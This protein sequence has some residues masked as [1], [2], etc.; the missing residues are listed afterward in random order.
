MK[1]EFYRPMQS[2]SRIQAILPIK[3]NH[4]Q[5]IRF[6]DSSDFTIQKQSLFWR[7]PPVNKNRQV[8]IVGLLGNLC[9]LPALPAFWEKSNRKGE[10]EHFRIW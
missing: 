4:S 1:L 9:D 6:S 2:D 5:P 3:N 7:K 10:I 8:V